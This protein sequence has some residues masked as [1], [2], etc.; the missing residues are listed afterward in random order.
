MGIAL[1]CGILVGFV[2]GVLS[3]V[4]YLVYY[5]AAQE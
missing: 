3:T 2:A 4:F 1:A 5:V